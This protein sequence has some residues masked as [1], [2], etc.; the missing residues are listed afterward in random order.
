MN[1]YRSVARPYLRVNR[2]VAVNVLFCGRSGFGDT[3]LELLN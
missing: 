2:A 1:R 3:V